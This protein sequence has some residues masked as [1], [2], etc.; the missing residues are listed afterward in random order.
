MTLLAII[1]AVALGS[2]SIVPLGTAELFGLASGK[3]VPRDAGRV[4]LITQRA[5][6][7]DVAVEDEACPVASDSVRPPKVLIHRS[8]HLFPDS[9]ARFVVAPDQEI[10]MR[11]ENRYLSSLAGGQDGASANSR[12]LAVPKPRLTALGYVGENIDSF[13]DRR[14]RPRVLHTERPLDLVLTSSPLRG[15]VSDT[16]DDEVGPVLASFERELS[17]SGVRSALGEPSSPASEDGSEDAN[18]RPHNRQPEERGSV[19]SGLSGSVSSFPLGAK[20]VATIVLALAA[21][22]A[23][24]VG[25]VGLLDRRWGRGGYALLGCGLLAASALPWL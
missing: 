9:L 10:G 11:N 3:A 13:E 8:N 22:G 17:A 25:F 6:V 19:R 20:V 1:S 23:G 24:V 16:V 15:V 21:W 7:G 12:I 5:A 18:R 4:R 2:G 14:R